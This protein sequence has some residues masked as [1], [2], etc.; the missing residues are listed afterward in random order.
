MTMC[1]IGICSNSVRYFFYYTS[2]MVF[3]CKCFNNVFKCVPGGQRG[4]YQ[5]GGND[6]TL[7]RHEQNQEQENSK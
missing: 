1:S 5:S 6:R 7:R 2:A 3:T 4:N